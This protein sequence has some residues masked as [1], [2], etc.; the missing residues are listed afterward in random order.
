M[1]GI[2]GLA[3]WRWIFILEGMITTLVGLSLKWT[4]ADGPDTAS[5]FTEGERKFMAA[6]LDS[7]SGTSSGKVGRH[8]KLDW[9]Q[10]RAAFFD[11]KIYVAGLIQFTLSVCAQVNL[12]AAF[13]LKL[14]CRPH[15]TLS[16][17]PCLPLST[18]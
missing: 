5:F 16:T 2:A 17:L 12:C 15:F 7:D 9:R 6:R 13:E 3:G 10:I 18:V 4:L 11:W 1:D 8:D 14:W